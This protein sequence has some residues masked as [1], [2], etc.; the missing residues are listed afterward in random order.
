M[1]VGIGTVAVSVQ[2]LFWE[3]MFQ[4]FGNSIFAE[5]CSFQ[6]GFTALYQKNGE[7]G[8]LGVLLCLVR[9]K[10]KIKSHF[11]VSFYVP[12]TR[13]PPSPTPPP[14]EP[15][16]GSS[17][18]WFPPTVFQS[19]TRLHRPEMACLSL[20]I[21]SFLYGKWFYKI[22][23]FKLKAKPPQTAGCQGIFKVL[24]CDPQK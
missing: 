14:C 1:N 7:R 8:W 23:S 4:I 9:K 20:S 3:Y 10:Y 2:F 15:V 5:C 16:L 19:F 22:Q 12:L 17:I 6:A 18:C 13:P 24:H 11:P 21:L